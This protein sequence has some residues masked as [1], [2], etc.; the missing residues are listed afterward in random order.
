MG[1]GDLARLP[2]SPFFMTAPTDKKS[3]VLGR[4]LATTFSGI[5]LLTVAG[6]IIGIA[7]LLRVDAA[8]RQALEQNLVSER[9]VEEAY[10]LQAINSERYKAMALSS[11]PE[12][13]EILAADIRATEKRYGE[14]IDQ[15][16]QRLGDSADQ[17][18]LA[19]VRTAGSDFQAAVKELVAARDSNLTAR[20]RETYSRRF[21]PSS[22][23]LL[24]A[25]GVLAQAQQHAIDAAGARIA[26]LSRSGRWALAL[27][28]AA[29]MLVGGVLTLWLARTISRPIRVAGETAARVSSLDLRQ[30]IEGHTRDEAGRLLGAL[31][32]MQDALR[33]LV[34]QVRESAQA[35]HVAAGEIAQG[36]LDLS[37]R[38]DSTASGLQQTAS[39]LKQM[40]Q[41]LQQSTVAATRAETMASNA[42]AVAVQGG[43]AVAHVVSTMQEIDQSSRRVADILTV[44]D[45]I[46]FQTNILALNAA[47]E[48]A[49]AGESGRGFS[50]VAAE[51][52]QLAIRSAA[53]AQ[54]IK[55]LIAASMRSVKAGTAL[56]DSA[57]STMAGIVES[58][59]DVAGTISEIAAATHAQTREI[60]QIDVAMSQ[61]DEVT[62]QNSTLVEESAAASEALRAQAEDLAALISRFVLPAAGPGAAAART[63]VDRTQRGLLLAPAR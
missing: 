61:L 25:V 40:T 24:Q 41:N 62:Q 47:V 35:V 42:A 33:A 50:V 52:R 3:N 54:E 8:T 59:Q 12:V 56:A 46:A 1:A 39:A 27:F 16:G 36:N 10:R 20:I 7:S 57:G 15:I 26:D 51:V 44:I 60:G 9:L 2:H 53:A 38:T 63:A 31:G 5:L 23:A 45:G 49:R 13:G 58:I 18:Q 29:A 11:E 22:A 4:R 19:Q 48:A 37:S 32:A 43:A 17:A 34:L 21:Q 55:G 14:L 30:D 6:S 28:S